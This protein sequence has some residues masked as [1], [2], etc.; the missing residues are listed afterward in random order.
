MLRKETQASMARP[1]EHVIRPFTNTNVIRSKEKKNQR[2]QSATRNANKTKVSTQNWSDEC[3]SCK[4]T[5]R[6]TEKMTSG[7]LKVCKINTKNKLKGSQR[8]TI[9]RKGNNEQV[10]TFTTA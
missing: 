8:H 5:K 2:E 9:R 3:A 1:R 7:K 6:I 10:K 4:F